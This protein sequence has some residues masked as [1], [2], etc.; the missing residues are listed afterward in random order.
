[1]RCMICRRT[2]GK[3]ARRTY[4]YVPNGKGGTRMVYACA[5]CEAKFDK[6]LETQN[7]AQVPD[8]MPAARVRADE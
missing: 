4:A 8:P 1:M 7:D 3:S 5:R 2:I 6:W